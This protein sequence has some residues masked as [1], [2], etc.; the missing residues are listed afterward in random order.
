MALWRLVKT[1]AIIGKEAC[2]SLVSK[3]DFA[4]TKSLPIPNRWVSCH[5]YTAGILWPSFNPEYCMRYISTKF[6]SINVHWNDGPKRI[7]PSAHTGPVWISLGFVYARWNRK[8]KY[9]VLHL[10]MLNALIPW[11]IKT[12]SSAYLVSHCEHDL[13][14]ESHQCLLA[15]MWLGCHAGHQEVR[16]NLI[17]FCQVQ[18]RLPS[19][20]QGYQWPH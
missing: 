11:A 12:F 3:P 19:P 4:C 2:N 15:G 1:T 17:Y 6:I 7:L 10:L 8:R 14:F 20:K 18:I 16:D 13:G 5:C 9:N